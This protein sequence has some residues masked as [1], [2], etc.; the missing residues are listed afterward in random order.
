MVDKNIDKASG[1]IKNGGIFSKAT[2][3]ASALEHIPVTAKG[4]ISVVW[5]DTLTNFILSLYIQAEKA[6]PMSAINMN[7]FAHHLKFFYFN[8]KEF[9][10]CQSGKHSQFT[11]MKYGK[12]CG[13]SKS[14]TKA[15]A[16][17]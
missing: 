16:R 3:T 17:K 9:P 2:D 7:R 15:K 6:M 4:Y 1:D 5:Q 8:S 11:G 14:V 12:V 10:G 13:N